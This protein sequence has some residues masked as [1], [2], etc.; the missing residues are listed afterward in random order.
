MT[1]D[2]KK[3]SKEDF[4]KL[5]KEIDKK[6]GSDKQAVIQQIA[7]RNLLERDYKEDV[8]EVVFYTSPQTQRKLQARRPTQKQMILIMKLSAEAALYETRLDEKSVA[9][10]TDIYAQLNKLA[11]ELSLDEKLDAKFWAEK[12]SFA[13]LQ[14][15]ITELIKETQ[16]GTGVSPEE[17]KNFR[18]ERDR[19]A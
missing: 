16:K 6:K 13:T 19:P 9:K 18:E 14:N 17:M 10:M 1:E 15:F 2:S 4:K 3:V 5:R 7:T 11:A 12:V 8:L